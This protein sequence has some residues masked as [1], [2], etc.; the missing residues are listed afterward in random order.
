MLL[1][2]RELRLLLSNKSGIIKYSCYDFNEHCLL[3]EIIFD[4]S[5]NKIKWS[6]IYAPVDGL[7]K[8]YWQA[9]YMEQYLNIDGTAKICKLYDEPSPKVRP[10]RVAFF[11][12]KSKAEILHTPYGDLSLTEIEELP[13][14]LTEII[15]FEEFEP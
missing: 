3:V 12:Y 8:D 14:R 9:P 10:C 1:L 7:E 11:V 2:C 15:E 13:V 5:S 6:E 4:I